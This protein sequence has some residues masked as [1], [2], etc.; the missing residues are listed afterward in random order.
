VLKHKTILNSHSLVGN[1]FYG[2]FTG[3]TLYLFCCSKINLAGSKDGQLS[4]SA[5]WQDYKSTQ[6]KRIS[7]LSV[8]LHGNKK[9]S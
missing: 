2:A 3:Y 6:Q 9:L 1:A 4:V 5:R 8:A 7:L